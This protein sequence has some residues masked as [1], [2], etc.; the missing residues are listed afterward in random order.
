ML[1]F[2]CVGVSVAAWSPVRM[3]LMEWENESQGH[4]YGDHYTFDSKRIFELYKKGDENLFSV[5]PEEELEKSQDEEPKEN[6][7]L[8]WKQQNF[9]ET[10]QIFH[11]T[12]FGSPLR[13]KFRAA[14]FHVL[15][16]NQVSFGP[17]NARFFTYQV[18][19]G[20]VTN[21]DYFID[22]QNNYID[23]NGETYQPILSW[24]VSSLDITKNKISAEEALEIAEKYG[25]QDTRLVNQN[26]CEID[27]DISVD[28]HNHNWVV[29]YN[30]TVDQF[31]TLLSVEIDKDT[32]EP[33]I[34]TKGGTGVYAFDSQNII[35]SLS[36]GKT[37]VFISQTTQPEVDLHSPPVTWTQKDYY[38]V[39]KAFNKI[40]LNE[41]LDR[42]DVN[43]ISFELDCDDAV[44]GLQQMSFSF[45]QLNLPS[46]DYFIQYININPRT[47]TIEW[48]N[49][50]DYSTEQSWLQER[51]R[52]VI[53]QSWI[54]VPADM[55]MKTVYETEGEKFHLVLKNN[56]EKCK[57]KG[58]LNNLGVQDANLLEWDVDEWQ[59]RED[60]EPLEAPAKVQAFVNIQTGELN[61]FTFYQNLKH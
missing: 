16:C 34:V 12:I 13:E 23:W 5:I 6:P 36:K 46:K 54:K 24:P 33:Q 37:D 15:D 18:V 11:Q 7:P 50:Y 56:G 52:E 38:Q 30:S 41:D 28:H 55:A 60:S 1:A 49:E 8:E 31:I 2:L 40:I 10:L 59:W 53:D 29:S 32:G 9:L 17:Q 21:Y 26:Q 61:F 42:W 22:L 57:I 48:S 58:W 20:E 39:A 14:T 47:N 51:N 3:I 45:V 35:E 27:I 25:G 44:H 43:Y 4:I 19:P